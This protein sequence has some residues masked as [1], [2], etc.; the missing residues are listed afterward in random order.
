MWL[1]NSISFLFF[2]FSLL[3]IQFLLV[4]KH[5]H[6]LSLFFYWVVFFLWTCRNS[7]EKNILG[8][9]PLTVTVVA[10][11]F[12]LFVVCLFTFSNWNTVGFAMLYKFLLYSK[13]T[14]II[15]IHMYVCVCVCVCVCACAK[16]LQLCLTLSD[17]VDCSPPGFFVHGISQARI[18][19]WVAI[20]F[21]RG[22]SWPRDRTQVS[23]IAGRFFT[24]WATREAQEW[25]AM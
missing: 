20:P 12:L 8:T 5:S 21:S 16:S 24:I 15:Y 10:N 13:V 19:E 1:S 9:H 22:S 7:F 11:I 17:S 18:L 2:F 4:E 25:L 23:C 14:V 6:V 3:A